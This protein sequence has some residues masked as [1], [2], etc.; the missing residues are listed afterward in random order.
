MKIK[1]KNWNDNYMKK[2]ILMLNK[3]YKYRIYIPNYK[4]KHKRILN[5]NK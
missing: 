2:N 1:F 3:K 4:K 5:Y